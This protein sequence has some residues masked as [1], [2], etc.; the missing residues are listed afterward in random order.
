MKEE[1]KNLF[2]AA[3][4]LSKS[5]PDSANAAES[6][7]IDT[8]YDRCKRMYEEIS[9]GLD[10]AFK[11]SEIDPHKFR[12]FF[13]QQGNFSQG[14]WQAIQ[15]GKTNVEGLLKNLKKQIAEVPITSVQ[16]S[17]VQI[18]EVKKEAKS[19]EAEKKGDGKTED[20]SEPEKKAGKHVRRRNLWL[21]MH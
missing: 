17:E 7:D 1:Y 15:L 8:F 13:M 16:A 6:T 18:S 5:A 11:Y 10:F 21:D 14:E 20:K 4:K 9:R 19:P 12:S 2:E 3:S